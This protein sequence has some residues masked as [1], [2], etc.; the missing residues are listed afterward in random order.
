MQPTSTGPPA[1]Q[2]LPFNTI[3]QLAAEHPHQLAAARTLLLVPDLLTHWLTGSIGAEATNASTTGLYDA[4]TA[5][6]SN[7]ALAALGIAPALL[8]PLRHPGEQAGTPLPSAATATGLPSTTPVTAVASY[9]TASA[10]PA[11]PGEDFA[12]ISCGT[13]S[14]AGFE[15]DR[16]VLTEASRRANFTNEHGI[17]GSVRYLRNIMGL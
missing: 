16:P 8:P 17:D 7:P 13:W 11:A 6:W 3:F 14:L 15:L 9:D 4:R 5:S 1:W 10:V 12:Y 2:H